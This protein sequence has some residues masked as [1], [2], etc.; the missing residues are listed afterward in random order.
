MYGK[1]GEVY[2]YA[3]ILCC[4]RYYCQY[5]VS[6]LHIM[7]S[8]QATPHFSSLCIV[9]VRCQDMVGILTVQKYRTV[10]RQNSSY[11]E[12]KYIYRDDCRFEHLQ[13]R[14]QNVIADRVR[15]G[16]YGVGEL[17]RGIYLP[18]AGNTLGG[19]GWT[20]VPIQ[21]VHVYR[22][23]IISCNLNGLV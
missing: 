11:S 2:C 1:D 10:L 14:E 20:T 13:Y 4:S 5:Q 18:H 16:I 9:Q 19:G 15:P 22:K 6:N 21:Y 3:E 8:N 17:D 12:K 23:Q 7:G